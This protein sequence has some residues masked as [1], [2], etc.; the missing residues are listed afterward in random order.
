MKKEGGKEYSFLENEKKKA[1]N[2]SLKEGTAGGFSSGIADVF[3]TPFALELGARSIHIGFLSSIASLFGQLSQFVGNN[4]M[5]HHDRKKI[6]LRFVLLQSIM[7]LSMVFL[8]VLLFKGILT[9][10]LP[11][12]LI[13]F[14]T[15]LSIFGGL[16]HPAWFSWMGDLINEKEKGKYFSKRNI[17]IGIASLTG[18]LIGGILLKNLRSNGYVLLGFSLL[19]FFAFVSRMISYFYF[20]IQYH[21]PYKQTKRAYFSFFSFIKKYDNFGK[22]AVYQSFFNFAIMFASPFFAVYMYQTLKFNDITYTIVTISSTLAYLVFLPFIGKFSDKYGNLRLLYLANICFIISPIPWIFLKTPIFLIIAQLISGLANAAYIIAF[23]NF[24]YSSTSHEHRGIC[25]AYTNILVGIGVFLGAISG[26]LM[27]NYASG[28]A[29]KFII[30][31]IM[32]SSLRALVALFFLPQIKEV[33]RMKSLPHL[34][35]SVMSPF[36]FIYAEISHMSHLS[37]DLKNSNAQKKHVL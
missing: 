9:G 29:N 21:P 22:F 30:L 24:I 26:G 34:A 20:K 3:I 35:R 17:I 36:R 15:L 4:L 12:F 13:L 14:Y 37:E 28:W 5:N 33:K 25:L 16:A 1:L 27:L 7:W 2:V 8:A 10:F 6:I 19:F 32:A 23:T 11:I 31:F 18:A